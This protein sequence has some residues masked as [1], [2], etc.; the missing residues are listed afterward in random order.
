MDIAILPAIEDNYIFVISHNGQALVIDPGDE[1]AVLPYLDSKGLDLSIIVNTHHHWDHVD[2]VS[3]LMLKYPSCEVITPEFTG[4]RFPA[5]T[6]RVHAEDVISFGDFN[7]T[8]METPGHTFDHISLFEPHH[9]IL[10]CGDTLFHMGCGRVFDGDMKSLYQSLQI[11]KALPLDTKVYCAHEYT[12]RNIAFAKSFQKDEK[13]D[14]L[15]KDCEQRLAID[16][17]TIPFVLSSNFEHN[18]FLTAPNLEAFEKLRL[19]KNRF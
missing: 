17:K 15:Q 11:L 18:P 16:G 6:K 19:L 12:L 13:L 2:G 9:R 14:P 10:F 7:F 4:N 5:S 3:P 1:K 8:V